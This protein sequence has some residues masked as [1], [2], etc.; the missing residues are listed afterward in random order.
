[1]SFSVLDSAEVFS[2]TVFLA[3]PAEALVPDSGEV[4]LLG[5]EVWDLGNPPLSVKI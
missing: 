2:L 5:V 3:D 1:V 4:F